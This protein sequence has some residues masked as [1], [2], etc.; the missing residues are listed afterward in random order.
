[1]NTSSLDQLNLKIEYQV[2]LSFFTTFQL[3]GPCKKGIIHCQTPEQLESAVKFLINQKEKFILI[4]GG[5][6]LVVSDGGLD[7]FVI[8]YVSEK[9]LITL[10]GD[11]IIVSAST[12]L[13]HLALFAAEHG[14]EGL[15]YTSGIPG[16][17]GGAI[18]C[19]AGSF[20]QQVGD[21]LE[22]IEVIRPDG[23]RKKQKA[24]EVRFT[25]Q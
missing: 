19:N 4:G 1:M 9:P 15:N 22:T 16:T 7:C 11:H 20:G 3:G 14:L 2:L 24:D 18:V 25:S 17:V 6:N 23:K 21:V 10:D 5:S 13:D 8:R 12:I